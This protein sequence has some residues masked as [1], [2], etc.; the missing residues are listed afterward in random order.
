M[1]GRVEPGAR[2]AET[3]LWVAWLL[4]VVC[5]VFWAGSSIAGRAA[6]GQVPPMTM[7]F[8]RWA[9][10]LAVLLPMGLAPLRRDWRV[11]ARHWPIMSLFGFLGVAGFT[12]PYYVGLQYT[13]AVNATLLN[14]TGPVL[15]LV[16]S[17]LLVGTPITLRQGGGIAVAMAGMIVILLRG[18]ASMLSRL[19]LNP[20]D[21]L[22]LASHLSWSVYTVA[23]RWAPKG[24]DRMSFLVAMIALADL[25]LLPPFLWELW[26]GARMELSVSNLS[27]IG[28]AAVFPSAIAYLL[29]N[30]AVPVV[31]ANTAGAV[32][33]L[34]PVFGVIGAVTLLGESLRL[35]HI[36]GVA[37]IFAGVYVVSSRR[38]AG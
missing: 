29:W 27:L 33:Y 30:R 37:L 10:A 11:I 23:L 35:F 17:L 2:P 9:I 12:A 36:V 31:G 1:A 18:D 8:W 3:K 4:L 32:Q 28:Y 5:T 26:T 38:P 14:A 7:S 34:I 25:M 19:E 13:D 20:G 15:I 22:V 21:L 16:C 6:A 24:L